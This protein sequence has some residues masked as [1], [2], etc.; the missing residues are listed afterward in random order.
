[1]LVQINYRLDVFGFIASSDL[2]TEQKKAASDS[3]ESLGQGPDFFANFGLVDQRNAFLWVQKHIQDFGGDPSNVTAVGVSAGSASLHMHILSGDPIF[4][5]AILMSGSAPVMGPL[6]LKYLEVAWTK[7]CQN[8]GVSEATPEKKLESLRSLS[9]ESILEK[10]VLIPALGPVA[11]G[12]LLPTA[13]HLGTLSA[14][15]RCKEIIVGDVRME[16]II[17]DAILSRVPQ[18][19]FRNKVQAVFKNAADVDHFCNYFGFSSSGEQSF[20]AFRDA[21]RLFLSVAIFHFP[22]LRVAE[23]FAGKVYYYHFEEPSPYEGPTYGLPVH[24]QCAVFLYNNEKAL[25]PESAQKVSSKMAD[26]W[27]AFAYGEEPWEPFTSSNQF[28]RFGP[29]GECSIRSIEDDKTRDY[30]YLGWL[31]G[32]FEETFAVLQG[33]M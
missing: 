29:A 24:G 18:A 1:M 2:A 32:H 11:D 25:W 27:T 26:V 22:A 33:L 5:R 28:M 14:E 19:A 23:N 9:A 16:G 7:L 21:M 4:D 3:S 30:G 15:S 17:F 20:E 10:S 8:A 12:R 13:W 6:P 31:R